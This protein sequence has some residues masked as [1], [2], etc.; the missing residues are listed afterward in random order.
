MKK[1]TSIIL[2]RIYMLFYSSHK[3]YAAVNKHTLAGRELDAEV[4]VGS[5][6]RLMKYRTEWSTEGNYE[7]LMQALTTDQRIWT[8]FQSSLIEPE[9]PMPLRLRKDLLQLSAF[10]DKRIF[11]IMADPAPEKLDI[12]ISINKKHSLGSSRT[13]I[14][15]SKFCSKAAFMIT[16]LIS[17]LSPSKTQDYIARDDK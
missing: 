7:A 15:H 11:E 10:V 13:L 8:I 6:T 14:E 9:H 17:M 1:G 4:L 3:T 2:R 5:A 12:H 16:S